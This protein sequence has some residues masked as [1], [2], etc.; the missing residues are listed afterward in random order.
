MEK[1]DY[2]HL[3]EKELFEEAVLVDFEGLKFKAPKGYDTILTKLYGDYMTPP[4]KEEQTTHHSNN[5]FWKE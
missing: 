1:K 5:T 2:L 3:F 4:P